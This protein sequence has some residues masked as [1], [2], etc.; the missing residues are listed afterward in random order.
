MIRESD[1]LQLALHEFNKDT[2]NWYGWKKEDV[3]GNKIDNSDRM[4][5]ANIEIIKEGATMPSESD[6]NSKITELKQIS[7]NNET[8][9]ASAKSKLEALGLTTEEIKQAFGI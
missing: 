7:S 6:V 2:P 3:D 4:T 8:V 1:W 9:K 5:Y